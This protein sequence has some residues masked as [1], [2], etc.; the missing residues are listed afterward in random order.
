MARP[1]LFMN[2]EQFNLFCKD[3]YIC[4]DSPDKVQHVFN[5]VSHGVMN[6]IQFISGIEMLSSFH[7]DSG[8][9]TK[10]KHG[11]LLTEMGCY[12]NSYKTKLKGTSPIDKSPPLT[13]ILNPLNQKISERK[14]FRLQKII[15]SKF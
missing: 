11:L 14:P 2:L 10:V 12:D 6:E 9:P 4:V 13:P 8:L 5:A 15:S 7:D 3:F 1:Y